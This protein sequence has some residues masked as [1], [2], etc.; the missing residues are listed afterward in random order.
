MYAVSYSSFRTSLA[1]FLD[2]VNEDHQ[3]ILITRQKGSP[4]VLLSL[5]DFKSYEETFYLMANRENA[6]RLERSIEHIQAGK[7]KKHDLLKE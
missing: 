6:K 1:N 5:E 2:K 3:P 7:A 4:A